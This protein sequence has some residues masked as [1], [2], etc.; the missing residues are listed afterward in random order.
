MQLF[1]ELKHFTLN[2]IATIYKTDYNIITLRRVYRISN[3]SY[4]ILTYMLEIKNFWHKKT[5]KKCLSPIF[6]SLDKHKSKTILVYN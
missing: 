5:C 3:L 1:L 2:K 6:K 4:K